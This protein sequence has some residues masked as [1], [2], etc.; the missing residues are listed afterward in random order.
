MFVIIQSDFSRVRTNCIEFWICFEMNIKKRKK[1]KEKHK[2][3]KVSNYF[4]CNLLVFNKKKIEK[5][6]GCFDF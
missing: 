3:N 5:N 6:I 4:P 1:K 2:Q